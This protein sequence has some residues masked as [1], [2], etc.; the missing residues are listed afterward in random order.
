MPKLQKISFNIDEDVHLKIKE[1][2]FRKHTTLT[3][4]YQKYIYEGL[5]KDLEE[6][7]E[8]EEVFVKTEMVQKKLNDYIF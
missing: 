1:L 4:I 8:E 2:S 7:D 3:E 6:M 5:K